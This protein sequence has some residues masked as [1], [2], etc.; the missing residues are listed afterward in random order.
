LCFKLKSGRDV[1]CSRKFAH[2][3]HC[4]YVKSNEREASFEIP[5]KLVKQSMFNLLQFVFHL[6]EYDSFF[7]TNID[8][9]HCPSIII[10]CAVPYNVRCKILYKSSI[11]YA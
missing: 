5:R 8:L 4:M 7:G 3:L 11:K 9:H 2:S 1:Q 10:Y 6:N